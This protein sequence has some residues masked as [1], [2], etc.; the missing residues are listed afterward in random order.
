MRRGKTHSARCASFNDKPLYNVASL[1]LRVYQTD[2]SSEDP[3]TLF[4]FYSLIA[5][6]VD[7]QSPIRAVL[8]VRDT[9][10]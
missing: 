1:Y 9:F 10:Y 4:L 6:E 3:S 2:T 7:I 5:G 8:L